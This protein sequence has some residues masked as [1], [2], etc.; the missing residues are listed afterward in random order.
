MSRVI[1]GVGDRAD[2]RELILAGRAVAGLWGAET[3]AV[4]VN[5]AAE[6]EMVAHL[7]RQ[8]A[9]LDLRPGDPHSVLKTLAAEADVEAVVVGSGTTH[10][11][12]GVS[13]FTEVLITELTTPVLVVPT[14]SCALTAL[15][16]V[17]VPLEDEVASSPQLFR[18]LAAMQRRNVTARLLHIHAPETVPA[19]A[20]H[21]PY[22]TETWGAEFLSRRLAT[23]G[24]HGDLWR[25]VGLP[26]EEIIARCRPDVADLVVLSWSQVPGEGRAPVIAETLSHSEIPVLLLAADGTG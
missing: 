3:V 18:W 14:G 20:D 12:L 23:G 7:Q 13:R 6:T 4:H 15:R 9:V 17:L 5:G 2:V 11:P 8:G 22:A 26:A 10:T 25:E 21:E 1:V 24:G 16:R 19:F